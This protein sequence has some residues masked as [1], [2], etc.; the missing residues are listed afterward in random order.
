MYKKLLAIFMVILSFS[1]FAKNKLKISLYKK[2]KYF[3][4]SKNG[5]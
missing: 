4:G 3:G 5:N 2:I 1:S